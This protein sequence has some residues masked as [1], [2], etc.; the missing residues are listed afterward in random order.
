MFSAVFST[1][2]GWIG[3]LL[4]VTVGGIMFAHGAQKLLGWFNGPGFDGIMTWLTQTKHLPWSIAFGVVM[5][6]FLG[7]LMLIAGFGTRFWA[8]AMIGLM[9]GIVVTSHIQ[10][11]FFM[12]WNGESR[13]EGFEYHLLVIGISLAVLV[14]GGGRYSLDRYLIKP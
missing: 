5:V 7:S 9:I 1:D 13:L 11:G 14:A 6:E 12:N 2:D 3:F 8:V 4:R 10:Q